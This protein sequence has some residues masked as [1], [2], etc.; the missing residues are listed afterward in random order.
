MI[1]DNN[2][3][4]SSWMNLI[5]TSRRIP[6]FGNDAERLR[7]SPNCHMTYY[8]EIYHLFFPQFGSSLR[9]FFLVNDMYI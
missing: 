1:W 7:G 4:Y 3:G 8:T 2:Q 6:D 5:M 9:C